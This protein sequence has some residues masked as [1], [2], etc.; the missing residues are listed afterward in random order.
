M[1]AAAPA[2]P[3]NPKIAAMIAMI[4]NIKAHLNMSQCK[5][6]RNAIQW[7]LWLICARRKITELHVDEHLENWMIRS[8]FN[9]APS[10]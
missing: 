6:R 3:A 1:D 8:I 9:R 7:V 10:F 4:K 2:I 5:F